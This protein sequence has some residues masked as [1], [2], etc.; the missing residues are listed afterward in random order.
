M[1]PRV[2]RP[3]PTPRP[4]AHQAAGRAVHRSARRSE[5][6]NLRRT[7]RTEP[8]DLPPPEHRGPARGDPRQGGFVTAETAAILPAIVA[9]L[10]LGLWA[11]STVGAKVRAIDAANSAAIAAAR[12]EDPQAV[13]AAYL[14]DGAT[15]AVSQ[16]GGLARVVVSVPVRPFGP[17]TAPV[18]VTARAAAPMEPGVP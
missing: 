2:R 3:S 12:S 5:H 15:V 6:R 10:A 8:A 4:T 11:V 9:V 18:S 13:A 7:A 16:D 17:L 14:P 1:T